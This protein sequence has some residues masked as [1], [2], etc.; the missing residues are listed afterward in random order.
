[1]T[2]H[3]AL[4]VSGYKPQSTAKIDLVNENKAIEEQALRQ[5]DRLATLTAINGEA[6]DI[7]KRWLAIGRTHLEQAWMAAN[8][9][10]FQP[11]RAKLPGE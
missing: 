9:S 6:V 2:E 4:P 3:T 5:L 10:V 1:M 11:T 7:D 8:R